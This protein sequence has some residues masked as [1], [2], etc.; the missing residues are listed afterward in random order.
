MTKPLPVSTAKH[1]TVPSVA[2]YEA[3]LF[4]RFVTTVATTA[5][6]KQRRLGAADQVGSG[7]KIMWERN[8]ASGNVV[9]LNYAVCIYSAAEGVM[10]F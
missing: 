5:A 1:H 4:G 2:V 8:L 10:P 7:S 9:A 6:T 3:Q